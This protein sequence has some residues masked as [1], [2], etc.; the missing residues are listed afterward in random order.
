M[1]QAPVRSGSASL[2]ATV[3]RR[4]PH[5]ARSRPRRRRAASPLLRRCEAPEARRARTVPRRRLRAPL[6]E[7]AAGSALR[8]RPG[9]PAGRTAARSRRARHPSGSSRARRR[10]HRSCRVGRTT[11]GPPRRP[12]GRA[13]GVRRCEGARF[14]P[15]GVRGRACAF[16]MRAPRDARPRTR[17]R[18]RAR[19][20]LGRSPRVSRRALPP[21]V[22]SPSG[23]RGSANSIT[24][25]AP[26]AAQP[27][28]ELREG[29]VARDRQSGGRARGRGRGRAG[30]APRAGSARRRASPAPG[31][32]RRDPRRAAGSS[33]SPRS[34]APRRAR[35]PRVRPRH[36]DDGLRVGGHA[37]EAAVV[38]AEVPG[39]ARAPRRP[40]TKRSLRSA[41]SAV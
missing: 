18:G 28:D 9:S 24:S 36:G 38:R 1:A 27:I 26:S 20:R 32:D 22:A 4:A 6:F 39:Q 16:R 11:A 5:P 8:R 29:N 37:R 41:S 14:R 17:L 12:T 2:P 3:G 40:R 33:A 34:A 31:R 35:R 23:R 21:G 25:R 15:G 19:T 10:T 7:P 30:P 13:D